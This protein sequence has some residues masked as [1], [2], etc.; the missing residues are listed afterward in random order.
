MFLH[1][2]SMLFED[3]AEAV[4]HTRQALSR[5]E[6]DEAARRMHTLASNAGFVCAY[7]LEQAARALEQ[8]IDTRDDT[9]DARLD[10]LQQHLERLQLACQPWCA[11][12]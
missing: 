5:G 1:L 10:E 8:A 3:N 7:T 9:V 12:H 2:L 6:R 4:A 11:P